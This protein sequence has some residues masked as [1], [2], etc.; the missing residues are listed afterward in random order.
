MEHDYQ[1]PYLHWE[2]SI[3]RYHSARIAEDARRVAQ[4]LVEE[5]RRLPSV[6]EVSGLPCSANEKLLRYHVPGRPWLHVRRTLD[7]AYY[8]TFADTEARDSDQVVEKYSRKRGWTDH[9]VL[10]VD[11]LWLWILNGGKNFKIC[12]QEVEE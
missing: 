6:E 7:Q 12:Q 4:S 10:M 1:M 3:A 8:P 5:N 2:R 9:R 11:Q